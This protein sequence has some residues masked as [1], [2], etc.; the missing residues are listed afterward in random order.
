M[1]LDWI[2]FSHPVGLWWLFLVSISIAN[3]A[4]WTLLHRAFRGRSLNLKLGILRVELMI[5]LCAAYVFG[6]A[7][8]AILPRADVQRICLFDT[9]LSSVAIGR[10]VATVAEICFVI[11]WA[12]VLRFLAEMVRS[13]L[14]RSVSSVIVPLIVL[15]ETCSWYAVLTTNY[16]GNAIENSLWA[17]SFLLVAVALV[18]LLGGFQGHMRAAIGA[19]LV[20]VVGYVAFLAVVDVPMYLARWQEDLALGKALLEPLAGLHDASTRWAVTHDVEHWKDEMAWMALYFS[21]AVWS[22]LALC[23][24][25]LVKH[26]L[27][28]YRGA[29]S[30]PIPRRFAVSA[31]AGTFSRA[32]RPLRQPHQRLPLPDDRARLQIVRERPGPGG[33]HHDG[34]AML[35]PSHLVALA[36]V[37]RAR[38]DVRAAIREVER[39]R[40]AVQPDAGHQD[41]GDRHQRD[42]VAARHQPGLDHRAFVLAEQFFDA[43]QGDRI[44]VPGIA[45]DVSY[46]RHTA[47]IRSM[48][49][50]IHARCQP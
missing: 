8:R 6:C 32:D 4:A 16:A 47:V 11:Q 50:M 44:H 42:E 40:Q 34:R 14:V 9:W 20:G 5:L 43:L 26:R 31:D 7:F 29:P 15:A 49:A 46:L 3:V 13:D 30:G 48:E 38:H 17:L 10:S 36:I 2:S 24:F 37:R 41:G 21:I 27:P 23:G 45:G 25:D 39:R 12:I 19:A 28:Q 1:S 35:E 33:Q 18:R 22:S